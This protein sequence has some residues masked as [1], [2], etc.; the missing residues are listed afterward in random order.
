VEAVSVLEA[1][2]LPR[3]AARWSAGLA[4]GLEQG[5]ALGLHWPYLNLDAGE[6]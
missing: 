1:T 5:E 4:L 2:E 6:M 3:N